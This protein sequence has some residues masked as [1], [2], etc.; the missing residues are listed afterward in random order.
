MLYIT[1]PDTLTFRVRQYVVLRTTESGETMTGAAEPRRVAIA[2]DRRRPPTA[3]ADEQT[4]DRGFRG[5]RGSVLPL[6]E[7]YQL[8]DRETADTALQG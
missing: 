2:P 6:R 4:A 8:S 1:V 7:G 5:F 3:A